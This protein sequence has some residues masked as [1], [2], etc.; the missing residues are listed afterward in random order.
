[1]GNSINCLYP[2]GKQKEAPSLF[3]YNFLLT[4]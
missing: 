2:F 4:S 3:S 1:M